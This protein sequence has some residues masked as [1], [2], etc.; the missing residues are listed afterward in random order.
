MSTEN[1][2]QMLIGDFVDWGGVDGALNFSFE[3][4]WAE[5]GEAEE[6]AREATFFVGKSCLKYFFLLLNY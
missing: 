6:D 2:F 5:G 3:T 4:H 1:A